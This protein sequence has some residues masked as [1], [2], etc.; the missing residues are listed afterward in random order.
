VH[1]KKPRLWKRGFFLTS[2]NE[3]VVL[4]GILTGE[5]AR[6]ALGFRLL[7]YTSFGWFFIMTAHLHLTEESF[8]LHLFLQCAQSLIDV[9][10]TNY[11]FNQRTNPPSG[12]VNILKTSYQYNTLK[13]LV[14]PFLAY[15]Q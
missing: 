12:Y 1:K 13:P 5:L 15:I 14:N 2:K 9:I 10:I 8:T 7:A 4:I 6:A 11:Y 3:L